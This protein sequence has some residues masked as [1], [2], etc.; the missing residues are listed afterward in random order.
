MLVPFCTD[1]RASDHS[2]AES[3][4][5]PMPFQPGPIPSR[6]PAVALIGSPAI[7]KVCGCWSSSHWAR[8]GPGFRIPGSPRPTVWPS[9]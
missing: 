5:L 1:T 6:A 4:G 7:E 8:P 9:A 3:H 2:T